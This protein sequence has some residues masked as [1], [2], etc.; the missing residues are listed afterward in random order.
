MGWLSPIIIK[1]TRLDRTNIFRFCTSV[2]GLSFSFY[3]RGSISTY[4]C[5]VVLNFL[6]CDAID[7]M[8]DDMLNGNSFIQSTY[9]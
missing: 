6:V 5:I 1:V 2:N 3:W 9:I 8:M 7:A 4:E